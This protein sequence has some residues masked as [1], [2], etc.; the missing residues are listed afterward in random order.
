MY[1]KEW[2]IYY[3]TDFGE[4]YSFHSAFVFFCILIMRLYYYYRVYGLGV[5]C[6]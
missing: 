2:F 4:L 1:L 3:Y 5:H 6:I